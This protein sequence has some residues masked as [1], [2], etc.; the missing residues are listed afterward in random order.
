M[1]DYRKIEISV[2]IFMLVGLL[3]LGYLS[4]RLGDVRIFGS[5]YYPVH[6]RFST[7]SGLKEKADVTMAGVEIGRVEEIKLKRGQAEV[8]LSIR[9]DIKLEEDV[10]ASIKTRG[11]IGARYISI[12]PGGLDEYI[13]P[14]GRIRDTQPPIDIEELVGKYVFGNVTG[15]GNEGE[16]GGGGGF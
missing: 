3:C 12:S 11:I 6:A 7:A 4:F 14:G 13:Q 1:E 2:G 15:D 5:N 16:D 9:E 10:I 8:I